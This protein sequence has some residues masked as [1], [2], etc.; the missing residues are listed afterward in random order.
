MGRRL[1]EKNREDEVRVVLAGLVDDMTN[2]YTHSHT[3]MS[4]GYMLNVHAIDLSPFEPRSRVIQS[5][6]HVH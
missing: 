2:P 4:I 5:E 6:P 3:H 1:C